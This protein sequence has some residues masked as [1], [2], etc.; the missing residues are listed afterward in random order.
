MVVK[1]LLFTIIFTYINFPSFYYFFKAHIVYFF[2]DYGYRFNWF[3]RAS[4]LFSR[5]IE[6]ISFL[7]G[8][9]WKRSFLCC[10]HKRNYPLF[11][12]LCDIFWLHSW[13]CPFLACHR[14]LLFFLPCGFS[15]HL[16]TLAS[17]HAIFVYFLLDRSLPY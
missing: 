3:M 8:F 1:F 5:L 15:L 9:C 10:I 16:F 2:L 12:N 6:R 13:T 11:Y 7:S 14:L 4:L 17:I